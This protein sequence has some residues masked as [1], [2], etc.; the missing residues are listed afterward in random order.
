MTELQEAFCCF[1]HILD[2][3][4]LSHEFFKCFLH[5]YGLFFS[6]NEFSNKKVVKFDEVE[7]IYILLQLVICLS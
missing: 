1:W 7:V 2:K 3:D 5:A 4:Y 6:L